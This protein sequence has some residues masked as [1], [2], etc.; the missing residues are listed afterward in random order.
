MYIIST[1]IQII[2]LDAKHF[3]PIQISANRHS[4]EMIRVI[5][6][7]TIATT[8]WDAVLIEQGITILYSVISTHVCRIDK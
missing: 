2:H 4:N 8:L 6:I 1:L 5:N 7:T 3:I